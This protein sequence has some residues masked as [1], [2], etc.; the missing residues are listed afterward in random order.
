M[1][2]T[3]QSIDN[4]VNTELKKMNN[5]LDTIRADTKELESRNCRIDSLIDVFQSEKQSKS[6]VKA[7]NL[8]FRKMQSE[9]ENLK[10]NVV[11]IITNGLDMVNIFITSVRI[12]NKI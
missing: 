1:G 7:L 10:S 9:N 8:M 4:K 3:A 6:D 11:S 5:G 12:S 2:K